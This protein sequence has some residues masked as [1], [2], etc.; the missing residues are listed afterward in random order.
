MN[1]YRA[2]MIFIALWGLLSFPG[3]AGYGQ[4]ERRLGDAF[5][6]VPLGVKGGL[7]ESNLSAY[8]VATKGNYDYVCLD[9]GT[10]RFGLQKAADSGLFDEAPGFQGQ[11]P[12]HGPRDRPGADFVMRHFI[13]A[14][15]ISHPHL[16]HIAGLIINSPEDSAKNI[17]GLSFCL[18]VL[19]D[20]YFTWKTWA[21]F[22][23]QGDRPALGKYHYAPLT[24][25]QE[26]AIAHTPLFVTAFPLSHS[27]PNQ[28][29]AFLLRSGDAYLLYLGDTGADQVEESDKLRQL[30]TSIAP[31]IRA[32]KLRALFIEVSYPNAQPQ[33]SLFGHLTPRLLDRE[34]IKLDSLAGKG[35]LKGFPILVTHIKPSGD[36]E[37]TIKEELAAENPLGV[38]WIFPEQ[39]KALSF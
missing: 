16:D 36:H 2:G 9:A 32:G 34:L 8:L 17:Y 31:L 30:W 3:L 37:A 1:H 19:R 24:A 10:L 13:K 4:V 12:G 11:N 35:S 6:V 26:T 22:G 5:Y 28:S 23:D 29:T 38:Q 20:H 25:G 27:K 33:K 39:A 15:L 18:E 21:N 14:Y 7:D